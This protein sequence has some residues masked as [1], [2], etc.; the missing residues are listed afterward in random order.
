MEDLAEKKKQE[1]EA[2]RKED[3]E[4]VRVLVKTAFHFVFLSVLLAP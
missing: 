1:E 3:E 4:K 2:K